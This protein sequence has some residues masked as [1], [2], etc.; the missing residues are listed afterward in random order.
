MF[1]KSMWKKL[2]SQS[3][4]ALPMA[5]IL[6]VVA[7][8]IV[9]PGL[10][11]VGSMAKVNQALETSTVGYYA[12]KAGIEDA[13]WQFK[14]NPGLIPNLTTDLTVNNMTVERSLNTNAALDAGPNTRVVTSVARLNG[15]EKAKIFTE[16]GVYYTLATEGTPETT[17]YPFKYAVGSTDGNINIE[18]NTQVRFLPNDDGIMADLWA[19]GALILGQGTTD[20]NTKISGTGYYTEGS[21]PN[22]AV[23]DTKPNCSSHSDEEYIFQALDLPWYWSKAKLGTSKYY[24]SGSGQW[25]GVPGWPNLAMPPLYN[26]S[27]IFPSPSVLGGPGNVSYIQGNLNITGT[28]TLKGGNDPA[29][30]TAPTVVWVDGYINC[31]GGTIKTDPLYPLA[32]Y[33]LF[34]HGAQDNAIY[35]KLATINANGN[36]NLM[37][38]NGGITVDK[39]N[40]PGG[41]PPLLGIIYALNG[42]VFLQ[43]NQK[44]ERPRIGAV[45]GK[46]VTLNSNVDIWYNTDLRN[47]PIG[48]FELNVEGTPATPAKT[49]VTINRYSW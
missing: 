16:I 10:W 37:A 27:A 17:G 48:G 28:V 25:E 15:E 46:R 35:I 49:E 47:N 11:A 30:P 32:Q 4:M 44:G 29:D 42:P 40:G 41:F 8:L 22:C 34:A 1:N 19:N 18:S 2:I 43:G 9:V 36:L 20:A 12:A 21:A 39:V 38:D 31:Q 13:C 24:N 33:Y 3:G 6:M 23:F 26:G 7:S 5:L 14:K 45:I